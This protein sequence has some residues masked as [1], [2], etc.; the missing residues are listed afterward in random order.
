MPKVRK[1]ILHYYSK[2]RIYRHSEVQVDLS[3]DTILNYFI[4]LLCEKRYGL[5]H[6]EA[7]GFCRDFVE[8]FC[9][10]ALD[11]EEELAQLTE[12]GRPVASNTT[13]GQYDD[14]TWTGMLYRP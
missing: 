7:R 14:R 9:F 12:K 6:S 2:G 1:A 10:V 8:R 11:V 13:G 5:G 4:K 3:M